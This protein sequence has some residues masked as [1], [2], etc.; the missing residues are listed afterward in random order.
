[1][2]PRLIINLQTDIR[3]RV[4]EF[5]HETRNFRQLVELSAHAGA[6]FHTYLLITRLFPLKAAL[7]QELVD[8][9][10]FVAVQVNTLDLLGVL[11]EKD[12]V[13]IVAVDKIDLQSPV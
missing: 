2:M 6:D 13:G 11:V 7:F 3:I 12:E 4:P 10:L 8:L 5:L 1:M 9:G